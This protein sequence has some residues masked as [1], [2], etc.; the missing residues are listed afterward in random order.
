MLP[1]RIRSQRVTGPIMGAF[2]LSV[3]DGLSWR[4]WLRG[5]CQLGAIALQ[6]P[7]RPEYPIPHPL[8]PLLSLPHPWIPRLCEALKQGGVSLAAS[9]LYR[10]LLAA[11]AVLGVAGLLAGVVMSG[12][13]TDLLR[14]VFLSAAVVLA[15]F[16]LIARRHINRDG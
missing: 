6:P 4:G 13:V 12:L 2:S 8:L 3:F 16:A 10:A 5:R 7:T 9:Q 15:L 1:R 11:A 14:L